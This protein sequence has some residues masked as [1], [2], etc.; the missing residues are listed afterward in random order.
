MVTKQGAK[1]KIPDRY[2][3]FD[4]MNACAEEWRRETVRAKK[5][6]TGATVTAQRLIL[7]L[8]N[9]C[10][11]YV[12]NGINRQ[13]T[14][15]SDVPENEWGYIGQYHKK[16]V[17]LGDQRREIEEK[18]NAEPKGVARKEFLQTKKRIS[19][20]IAE[21]ETKL[22]EIEEW[23]QFAE[24]RKTEETLKAERASLAARQKSE[25]D[26]GQKKIIK[27]RIREIK[28]ALLE[29]A[30]NIQTIRNRWEQ[31]EENL[32]DQ[33]TD[34]SE[35]WL[36]VLG[37][38]FTQALRKFEES[39]GGPAE[40]KCF[41]LWLFEQLP[42]AKQRIGI[43]G[44]KLLVDPEDAYYEGI[45]YKAKQYLK[46]VCKER[47][48]K[49][50][51][52]PRHVYTAGFLAE[53]LKKLGIS[54]R[55]AAERAEA[56]FAERNVSLDEE[57]ENEER[58]IQNQVEHYLHDRKAERKAAKEAARQLLLDVYKAASEDKKLSRSRF[59]TIRY[60][61]TAQLFEKKLTRRKAYRHILEQSFYQKLAAEE[62]E[63]ET[64]NRLPRKPHARLAE[65]QKQQRETVRKKFRSAQIIL[66]GYYKTVLKN[67]KESEADGY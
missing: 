12:N 30:N 37:E 44:S 2:D 58:V 29:N 33:A 56:L 54:A 1:I 19:A 17:E 5:D 10:L 47:N 42:N 32:L 31:K 51:E 66:I 67:K 23:K 46:K 64:Q 38:A 59:E 39:Y 57:D 36:S 6:N 7:R 4:V 43:I 18:I 13:R 25:T 41:A 65:M 20:K 63:A 16:I 34:V 22:I 26:P 27:K 3:K 52:M 35:A 9:E 53:Q 49:D 11:K 21:L 15:M 8:Y 40:G 61:L 28:K 50:F 62:Q 45:S 24:Y 48:I 55:D 60:Y 14:L